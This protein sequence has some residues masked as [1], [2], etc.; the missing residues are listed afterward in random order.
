[1]PFLVRRRRTVASCFRLVFLFLGSFFFSLDRFK[2]NG[3]DCPSV[4]SWT[5]R[6]P[7]DGVRPKGGYKASWF[8]PS[9]YP[10]VRSH[11]SNPSQITYQ[12]SHLKLKYVPLQSTLPWYL[13]LPTSPEPSDP[14]LTVD[15]SH[16][17]PCH[18]HSRYTI[19]ISSLRPAPKPP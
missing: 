17:H 16:S 12:H 15:R 19:H 4:W 11:P 3:P 14:S 7:S 10:V 2:L 6:L 5:R 9:M 1:M 18:T 8:F 13:C